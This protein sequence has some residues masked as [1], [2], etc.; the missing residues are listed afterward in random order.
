MPS[1]GRRLP[2]VDGKTVEYIEIT[3]EQQFMYVHIRFGDKTKVSIS[4]TSEVLL[5]HAALY[6]EATSNLK[7]LREYVQPKRLC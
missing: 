1:R 3:R 4:F 7:V 6:D 2:G 5:Y